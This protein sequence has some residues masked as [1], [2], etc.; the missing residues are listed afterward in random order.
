MLDKTDVNLLL[1]EDRTESRVESADTLIL[2]D[3]TEAAEETRSESGLRDETD[4]SGFKRAKGDISEELGGGG[5]GKVDSGAV[6]GGGLETKLVDPLLLEELI[7]TELE[8]TLKEVTGGG[9]TETSKESAST[10]VG[11]DLTETTDH[12][13]VVGDGVKLDSGLDAA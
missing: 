3:L 11:N 5:R 12:T 7:T 4:T 13:T 8:S 1:E 6:V 9:R 10:L 2:E